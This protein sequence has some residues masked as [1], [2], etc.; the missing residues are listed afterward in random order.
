MNYLSRLLSFLSQI[1]NG[2]VTDTDLFVVI[3]RGLKEAHDAGLINSDDLTTA[4]IHQSS[5]DNEYAI[6]GQSLLDAYQAQVQD[7]TAQVDSKQRTIENE[8]A[9]KEEYQRKVRELKGEVHL[10]NVLNDSYKAEI[11]DLKEQL[12]PETCDPASPLASCNS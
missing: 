10:A 9:L 7:L 5:K 3:H 11:K 12:D 8:T 4:R 6:V 1:P 2:N